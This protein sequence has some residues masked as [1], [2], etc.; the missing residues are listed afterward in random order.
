MITENVKKYRICVITT[1]HHA[2]DVR[3]F[4]K[5][6]KYLKNIASEIHF[7]VRKRGNLKTDSDIHYYW[8]NNRNTIWGRIGRNIQA[9]TFA[10]KINVDIY[11]FHDPELIFVGFL[12]KVLTRKK[13]IYDIHEL[14]TDAI[15]HRTY[16]PKIIRKLFLLIYLSLERLFLPYLDALILAEQSYV[17]YYKWHKNWA[18]VQNFIVK[19]NLVEKLENKTFRPPFQIVY[20]GGITPKRGIWEMLNFIKLLN[21]NN[22]AFHFHLVGGFDTTSLKKQVV[23]WL[24]KHNLIELITIY[25]YLPHDKALEILR[26]GQIGLLFLHPI[27]NNMNIL[28]TKLFEYMGNGMVVF[29]SN[30]PK[31][32]DLNKKHQF[33]LVIDIFNLKDYMPNVLKLLKDSNKM[34]NIA[35]RNIEYVNQ[36][37]LWEDEVQHLFKLYE[38]LFNK[39]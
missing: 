34:Q 19:Q 32:I 11:H 38:S 35:K 12:L 25:N 36:H 4:K 31:W 20:L 15:L 10:L 26:K 6:I 7:I 5:E 23:D 2:D 13:V 17:P 24:Q 28:P 27:R 21:E 33:G 39:N 8:M 16:L 29:A 1:Q 18:I 37:Y 14:Y 22:I 3:I 30:F 9:L